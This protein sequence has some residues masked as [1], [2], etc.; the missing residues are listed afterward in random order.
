[1]MSDINV[2]F[3]ESDVNAFHRFCK[4]NVRLKSNK[5]I[6]SL[7]TGKVAI[8]FLKIKKD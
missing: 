2:N 6:N 5:T 7:S 4:R 8:K 3:E 1:M